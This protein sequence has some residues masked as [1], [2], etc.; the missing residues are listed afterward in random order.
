MEEEI[1]FELL[2]AVLN[3]MNITWEPDDHTVQNI[4]NA[5]AEARDYLRS[6]AG[7]PEL[8]FETGEKRQLLIAC[9]W[10][11]VENKRAEFATEYMGELIA[12]RL[13]EGFGCGAETDE[14]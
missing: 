7:N 13:Q 1:S 6:H 2:H 8:T 11:F 4:R 5:I 12:L 14:I 10:Y 9:A 3:R